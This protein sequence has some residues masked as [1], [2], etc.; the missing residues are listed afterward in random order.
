M[1][2]S[3]TSFIEILNQGDEENLQEETNISNLVDFENK[4][5]QAL[6]EYIMQ[7][8]PCAFSSHLTHLDPH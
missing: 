4:D 5:N 2:N 6:N 3:R 1:R 8:D 7:Q